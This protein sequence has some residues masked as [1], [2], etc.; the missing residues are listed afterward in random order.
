MQEKKI[1]CP[2]TFDCFHTV[3]SDENHVQLTM[4]TTLEA[5]TPLKVVVDDPVLQ[6]VDCTLVSA[7]VLCFELHIQEVV[8]SLAPLTRNPVLHPYQIEGCYLLQSP[9]A[10]YLLWR[11]Q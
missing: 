8:K 11:C 9:C 4:S 10:G 6:L 1:G 3:C 5:L 2:V 7:F